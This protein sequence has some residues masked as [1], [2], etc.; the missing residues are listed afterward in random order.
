MIYRTRESSTLFEY[1]PTM[2]WTLLLCIPLLSGQTTRFDVASIHPSVVEVAESAAKLNIVTSPTGVSL[3]H[4]SLLDCIVWAYRV[5]R[6]DVNGPEWM[7]TGKFDIIAKAADS[8]DDDRRREMMRNLLAERFRLRTHRESRPMP[9]YELV[10]ASRGPKLHP[11][12][13]D[14]AEMRKLPGG[15]L[16]LDFRRTSMAQLAEFLST[17]AVIARPVLDASG[18][19]GVYDFTLDLHEVSGPWPSEAERR[20]APSFSTVLQEQLG[21]RLLSAKRPIEVLVVDYAEQPSAN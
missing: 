11:S 20:A 21:L 6:G 8:G 10:P 16:R 2:K 17:L 18:Q 4:A 12:K 7:A 15:G 1:Y 14:A 13:F 5:R 19:T 9:V 3:G